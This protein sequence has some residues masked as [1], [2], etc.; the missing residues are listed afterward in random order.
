MS[1]ANLI[2]TNLWIDYLAIDLAING[3]N[4][5]YGR[6]SAIAPLFGSFATWLLS[7]Y[8]IQLAY[9]GQ[10]WLLCL[11]GMYPAQRV[12]F[13]GYVYVPASWVFACMM[14]G[15][16]LVDR[17]IISPAKFGIIF[18]GMVNGILVATV[19]F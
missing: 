5:I 6:S 2:V 7:I 19:L 8:P 16:T 15:V 13:A 4:G 3:T 10:E 9:Q 17:K 18:G 11:E 1:A 14:F 12:G